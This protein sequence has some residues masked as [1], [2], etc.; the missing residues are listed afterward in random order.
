[1]NLRPAIAI[2]VRQVLEALAEGRCELWMKAYA[3]E[4]LPSFRSA[5]ALRKRPIP[6]VAHVEARQAAEDV[7]ERAETTRIRVACV[8]R[9]GGRGEL[10][11]RPLDPREA[12]MCHL[13][14]GSGKRRQKQAVSNCLMEHH[15]CHQGPLGLDRKP[16]AWTPAVEA[17]AA[18]HGYPVPERFQK[19]QAL[20]A[21]EVVGGR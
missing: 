7:A 13:D 4:A 1:M 11:G 12:E 8:A 3:V 19:L 15:E 6:S 5:P 21:Q 16:S 14:G 18:R 9:A 2:R 20:R 17:W 10:C